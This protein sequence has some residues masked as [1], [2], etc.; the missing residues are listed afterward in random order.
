V[1]D[2]LKIE[3]MP[4]TVLPDG[5]RLFPL[6]KR[7]DGGSDSWFTDKALPMV[8]IADE[9]GAFPE[10]TDDGLLWLDFNRHLM[11]GGKPEVIHIP[12]LTDDGTE[13]KT[14]SD[15]TTLMCLSAKYRWHINLHGILMHA[16]YTR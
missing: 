8:A 11:V 13:T 16:S 9:S 4:Y 6:S 7:N 2:V 14:I 10:L 15:M 1:T 12:L 5:H 3:W